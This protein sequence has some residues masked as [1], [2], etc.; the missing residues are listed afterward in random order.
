MYRNRNRLLSLLAALTLLLS[1]S[2]IAL[3]EIAIGEWSS[4]VC[5]NGFTA[6]NTL[7]KA[8]GQGWN[9]YYPK[10]N[11]VRYA[12]DGYSEERWMISWIKSPVSG[13]RLSDK[14]VSC[15]FEDDNAT[16]YEKADQFNTVK[17]WI[18]NYECPGTA[19]MRS[20]GEFW[21]SYGSDW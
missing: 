7:T 20:N 11:S 17:V 18:G 10:A 6:S 9:S 2:G 5:M 1:F 21:A 14:C 15:S 16:I 3:A 13:E 4:T 8:A 19:N 12:D